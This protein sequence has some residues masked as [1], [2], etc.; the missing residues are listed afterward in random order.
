MTSASNRPAA[1][2][3]ARYPVPIELITALY[4]ADED[5][6]SQLVA[7]LHFVLL[8]TGVGVPVS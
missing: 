1:A 6:F 4:R 2:S 8:D 5:R 7:A 3:L